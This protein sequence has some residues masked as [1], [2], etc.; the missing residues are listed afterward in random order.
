[1]LCD[2]AGLNLLGVV[3]EARGQRRAAKRYYV[4]AVRADPRFEP[5]RQNMRRAYEL[6]TLGRT[7]HPVA[8]GDAL[9]D[10]WLDRNT[11]PCRPLRHHEPSAA[12]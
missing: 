1:M 10:L 8:V 9:T 2:A 11:T 4:R 6:D 12:R 3:C 7:D 5:A